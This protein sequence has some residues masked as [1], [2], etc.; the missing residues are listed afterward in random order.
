MP[1]CSR[2]HEEGC[3]PKAK[4]TNNIWHENHGTGRRGSTGK[5]PLSRQ[6]CPA[7]GE[8]PFNLRYLM[9]DIQQN[10]ASLSSKH[11]FFRHQKPFNYQTGIVRCA[12]L[13]LR[14]SYSREPLNSSQPLKRFRGEEKQTT[15][16]LVKLLPCFCPS[17]LLQNANF[18]QVILAKTSSQAL[19]ALTMW[20][21]YQIDL[22]G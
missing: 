7:A 11:C 15:K 1:G 19:S 17:G 10:P 4:K 5:D 9:S 18:T 2:R 14:T 8:M 12:R 20:C 13:C 21:E 22:C 3:P 16:N 6:Q